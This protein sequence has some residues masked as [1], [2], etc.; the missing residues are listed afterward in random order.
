MFV[1][2]LNVNTTILDSPAL[3]PCDANYFLSFILLNPH[4]A[5]LVNGYPA[6]IQTCFTEP[7]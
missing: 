4:L 5:F 6:K 2:C 7:I 3:L 1:R